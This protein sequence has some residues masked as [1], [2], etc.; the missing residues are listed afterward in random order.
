M[1]KKCD[2]LADLGRRHFMTGGAAAAATVAAAAVATRDAEATNGPA[3]V[4]YPATKL[5]NVK[6]LK[7][8][9]PVDIAYPDKD[10]P[11][12]LLK[13]GRMVEGGVGPQRDI[14]AFSTM[15]PHKGFPLNYV[16]SDK[17]LNCPGHYSRFDVEKGGQQIWGQS[18]QN[19]AQFK[20]R[21]DA[22]GNIFAAGV[23]EL[24]YGRLSNV[25]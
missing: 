3:L 23:D 16:A 25:L 7:V 17:S 10:S 22:A 8:D 6:D 18:T 12:L 20:L 24:L 19:L 11:G 14:V 2:R 9:Q 15:C 5:G 1:S 13:V 21:V 4:R